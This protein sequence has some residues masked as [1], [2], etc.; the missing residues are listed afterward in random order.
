LAP[1]LSLVFL[2]NNWKKHKFRGGDEEFE[3]DIKVHKRE[4]NEEKGRQRKERKNK[5]QMP[6]RK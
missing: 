6:K 5:K 2:R 4:R 3:I 1:D